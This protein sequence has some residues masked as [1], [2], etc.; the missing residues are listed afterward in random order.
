MRKDIEFK[1]NDGVTLRGWY[2]LPEKAKKN[3][4]TIVMAHGYSA[5]KEMYLDSFAE[6]FCDAGFA[7]LVY[8]N[9]N[10]GASD[11]EPR[12]EIDPWR[13]IN[14][15]RDAITF[16]GTLSEVDKSRIGVWGSS[17][18]GGHVIVVAALDRRVKCVVC[19]VP[20]ISGLHNARRLV[21]SDLFA[22]LRASFDAD[23]ESI[24]SGNPPAMIKVVAEEPGEPCALP[25][26]DSAEFFFETAKTRAPAWIN[27]VTLKSV[28]MF[29]DYEPG[30][31][32]SKISPTPFLLAVAEGDHLVVVDLA[33]EAY[34]KALEPKKLLILPGGHFEAYTGEAFKVNSAA[35]RDWFVQH[36]KP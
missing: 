22:G 31:Y 7:V 25:T 34:E 6:V 18:S 23:R 28:E 15:Y 36:L 35:Q 1:T 12:Q 13:Q 16:A 14:D 19:Q 9:R 32:I 2:Y 3:I 29:V 33:L 5:V 20:L 27:E 11:G 17:Y 10:L 4:P 30:D 24:C 26:D 21:R 8:D